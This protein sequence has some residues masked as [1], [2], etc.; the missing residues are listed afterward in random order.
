MN[1]VHTHARILCTNAQTNTH[2]Y[3]FIQG[4][5]TNA[6]AIASN[7]ELILRGNTLV[8]LVLEPTLYADT[9]TSAHTARRG[10]T[11]SFF[12]AV[13]Q[14]PLNAQSFYDLTGAIVSDKTPLKVSFSFNVSPHSFSITVLE[15]QSTSTFLAALLGAMAGTISVFGLILKSIESCQKVKKSVLNR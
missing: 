2:T 3:T 15:K 1:A 6:R 9:T 12:S 7:N 10:Y 4:S 11:T 5:H 14:R 8:S 13:P